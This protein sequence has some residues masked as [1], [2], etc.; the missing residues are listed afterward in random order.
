[1]ATATAVP[2][3]DALDYILL[4]NYV[5]ATRFATVCADMTLAKWTKVLAT[6]ATMDL[7]KNCLLE[8]V[9]QDVTHSQ[10]SALPAESASRRALKFLSRL[11]D[12]TQFVTSGEIIKLA[13]DLIID[14]VSSGLTLGAV[15]WTVTRGD[16]SVSLL[17]VSS[18]EFGRYPE[19]LHTESLAFKDALAITSVSNSPTN[20]FSKQRDYLPIPRPKKQGISGSPISLLSYSFFDTVQIAQGIHEQHPAT[21]I[22]C[23]S[24]VI[25]DVVAYGN[26]MAEH[27]S[28]ACQ[29]RALDTLPPLVLGVALRMLPGITSPDLTA[30]IRNLDQPCII[31]CA[32]GELDPARPGDFAALVAAVRTVRPAVVLLTDP[33]AQAPMGVGDETSWWNTVPVVACPLDPRINAMQLGKLAAELKPQRL[34][35][36]PLADEY[37]WVTNIRE[38]AEVKHVVLDPGAAPAHVDLE[39]EFFRVDVTAELGH[40]IKHTP[41]MALGPDGTTF[42]HVTVAWDLDTNELHPVDVAAAAMGAAT[43]GDTNALLFPCD[44]TL[45][46]LLNQLRKQQGGHFRGHRGHDVDSST[47]PDD[48][49]HERRGSCSR[50]DLALM[51]LSA[52]AL[53][54]QEKWQLQATKDEY[55]AARDL[56]AMDEKPENVKDEV[57]EGAGE[58]EGQDGAEDRMDEDVVKS[59]EQAGGR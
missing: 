47:M 31:L 49:M 50:N 30:T 21:T 25:R 3:F 53:E 37:A 56:M 2:G 7:A 46:S 19:Q 22:V 40:V 35:T 8:Q 23:V 9:H 45:D 26:T 54:M 24:P 15:N 52:P 57:D 32:P 29:Q 11:T 36:P 33:L 5:T 38:M 14:A 39:R 43:L 13:P 10:R 51:A 16:K 12:Q 20:D 4:S 42:K 59:E 48:R 58:D 1:M 6:R 34:L 55:G 28:R 27:L 44:V 18:W 17:G 41:V